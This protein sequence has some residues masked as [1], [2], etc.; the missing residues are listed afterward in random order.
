M[1]DPFRNPQHW[2]DRVALPNFEK[3]RKR[4]LYF[5]NA[6]VAGTACNVSRAT[7]FSGKYCRETGVTST[8]GF[9]MPNGTW[10][11]YRPSDPKCSLPTPDVVKNLGTHFKNAATSFQTVYKGKWHLSE[12]EG[13]WP[14]GTPAGLDEYDF[15]GW[16][17]PEGHGSTPLRWGVGVDPPYAQ[18]TVQ[19][20]YDL[21]DTERWLLVSSLVNP[22]DVGFFAQWPSAIPNLGIE[23]PKNFNWAGV[24]PLCQAIGRNFWNG[25]TFPDGVDEDTWQQYVQFYAYL[26]QLADLQLGIILD[27]LKDSGQEKDTL[28]VFM[29]D[30]GEMAASHRMT[31]KWYQAYEEAIHVPLI[32][33]GL[34]IHPGKTKS[35]A[36]TIDLAPTL[37]SLAGIEL[38]DGNDQ[39]RGEDLSPVLF[40]PENQVQDGVLFLTD[41]NIISSLSNATSDPLFSHN[42]P[43]IAGYVKAIEDVPTFIRAIRTTEWKFIVY[44]PT[45]NWPLHG[46]DS[47]EFELYDMTTECGKLEQENLYHSEDQDIIA[48][49]KSQMID[50]INQKYMHPNLNRRRL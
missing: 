3:L 17:P 13:D 21:C 36:S 37:L 18:E 39:L 48:S 10:A 19:S 6:Y 45:N 40:N 47:C 25:R 15:S 22:H 20:L 28:V 12:V 29:A 7:I 26:T 14:E 49:L 34:G 27:A 2:Q 8:S 23:L 1:C 50:L 38:P 42:Y 32:F 9:E 35:L 44:A 16:Q 41:D 30:H 5:E 33:S 46:N 11:G 24:K 43:Q 31:Q 4:G